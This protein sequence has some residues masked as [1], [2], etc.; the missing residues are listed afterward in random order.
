MS[1]IPRIAAIVPI[2]ANSVRVPRKNFRDFGGRPLYTHIIDTLIKCNNIAEVWIDTDS[3]EIITDKHLR[4][5]VSVIPRPTELQ[6]DTVA[7][8]D[9]LLHDATYIDTPFILQTH[10]TNPLLSEKTI[11]SAIASFFESKNGYD[12]LFSVTRTQKR[13]FDKDGIPVNHDP[14]NLI[15]TQDLPPLY[16]EN[17]CI[18]LFSREALLKHRNRI[19]K[20]PFMFEIPALEAIDIDEEHDFYIAES[21][22]K[23]NNA[24]IIK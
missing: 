3:D 16:E 17:S 20:R 8:N 10:C 4:N 6:P 11:D 9:I 23:R 1:P 22:Y 14:K 18:Y 15:R 2:R 21:I 24:E 5:H 13:F 7:M 12:S 19:G